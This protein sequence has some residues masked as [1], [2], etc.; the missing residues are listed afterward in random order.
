MKEFEGNELIAALGDK[1]DFGAKTPSN[2]IPSMLFDIFNCGLFD[3]A[4][5][6]KWVDPCAKDRY[7]LIA[8]GAGAGGL[9]SAAGAKGLGAKVAIIERAFM[10]GD[11]LNSG[12]VP[13][14]A[15]LA[16]AKVASM[17]KDSERFGI[18]IKGEVEVDFVK[19][20]ERVRHVR[21]EIS[22]MDSVERFSNFLGID[23]FLG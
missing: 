14:K 1:S 23:V 10:G 8:I 12:C 13:S 4:R 17:A 18:K 19:V 22:E 5:P 21:A 9:V 3:K 7:D 15:L 6:I 2:K 20:M 11:C 16:A